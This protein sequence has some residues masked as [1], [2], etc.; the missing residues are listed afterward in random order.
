[1]SHPPGSGGAPDDPGTTPDGKATEA[2]LIEGLRLYG[3]AEAAGASLRLIGS[4]AVQLTCPQWKHLATDLEDVA[5]S[6]STSWGTR[7]SRTDSP[8]CSPRP[9][10]RF[11]RRFDTARS[12]A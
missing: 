10:S 9:V 11:T 12:M 3:Q 4:L 8:L 7:R 6:T 5:V 2:L 1:M